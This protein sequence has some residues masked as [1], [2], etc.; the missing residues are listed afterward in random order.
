MGQGDERGIDIGVRKCLLILL[1]SMELEGV[2]G[3]RSL[4]YSSQ[5][6]NLN[7][8]GLFFVTHAIIIIITFM[9]TASLQ[10]YMQLQKDSANRTTVD[11]CLGLINCIITST[12]IALG[13]SATS[14][15]SSRPLKELNL[16]AINQKSPI[17]HVIFD[18]GV[19]PEI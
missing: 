1:L 9:L 8:F 2:F 6:Y 14:Q 17:L 11:S 18:K 15:F 19:P 10:N 3:G 5:L 16:L 12:C 4:G 7:T 13:R